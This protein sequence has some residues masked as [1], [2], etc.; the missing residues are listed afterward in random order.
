[1]HLGISQH[2]GWVQDRATRGRP[3]VAAG[4]APQGSL[5]CGLVL[6]MQRAQRTVLRRCAPLCFTLRL[7]APSG[8]PACLLRACSEERRRAGAAPAAA[9]RTA[10][11]ERGRV[12]PVAESEPAHAPHGG[13]SPLPPR[14]CERTACKLSLAM[15]GLPSH[16]CVWTAGW[17][18]RGRRTGTCT[19]SA[20][21]TLF[22]GTAAGRWL[23]RCPPPATALWRGLRRLRAAPVLRRTWTTACSPFWTASRGWGSARRRSRR[24]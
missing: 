10:G 2:P 4:T 15:A 7:A 23:A 24:W 16:T 3:R 22:P 8:P 14:V 18:P 1:M 12:C 5:R 20:S 19:D 6:C 11:L 13:E 21:M 9:A 17:G